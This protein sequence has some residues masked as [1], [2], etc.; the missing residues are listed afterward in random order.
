VSA[1][2]SP[3]DIAA[4]L[5]ARPPIIRSRSARRSGSRA[6]TAYR[7]AGISSSVAATQAANSTATK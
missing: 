5:S 6:P 1:L 7:S 3:Q 2:V 4:F